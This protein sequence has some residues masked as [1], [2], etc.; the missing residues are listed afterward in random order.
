MPIL[1]RSLCLSNFFAFLSLTV[2]PKRLATLFHFD[3]VSSQSKSSSH[4]RLL[5]T[6]FSIV[7]NITIPDPLHRST[8]DCF[9]LF[10][11]LQHSQ[12]QLSLLSNAVSIRQRLLPSRELQNSVSHSFQVPRIRPFYSAPSQFVFWHHSVYS[13]N[14]IRSPKQG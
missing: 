4:P 3:I 10:H 2:P 7:M 8:Y 9:F 13:Y 14:T 6:R 11:A 5:L 1:T 12:Q